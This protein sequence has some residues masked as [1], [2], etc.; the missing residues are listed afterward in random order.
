MGR[1]VKS[2][3]WLRLAPG[4]WAVSSA[5]PIWERQLSAAV[6]S[7]PRAIVGGQAAAAIHR[8]GGF[9]KPRPVII[10]PR[11]GNARSP[12]AR[13]IRSAFFRT[14]E[15]ERLSGFLVTSPAETLLALAAVLDQTRLEAIVDECFLTGKVTLVQMER[16]YDRIAGA[17]IRGSA[18]LRDLIEDRHPNHYGVDSTYLERL[19]EKLLADP[20]IP[21]WRREYPIAINGH[22]ARLDAFIEEWA[23]N[24]EADGRRWHARMQALD[25]DHLRDAAL[26]AQGIQVVRLSYAMLKEDPEG[27]LEKILAAGA[28]RRASRSA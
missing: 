7:R 2:G 10:V 22:P 9:T 11:T 24:I 12:L 5:P 23:M 18:T 15:V 6:L 21:V 8:I 17:R 16:I 27:C 19:L 25:N 20:R 4:V 13:V 28:H 1:N 26:A 14:I 3:A